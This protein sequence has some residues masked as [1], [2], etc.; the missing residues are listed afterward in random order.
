MIF[1]RKNHDFYH[2][3]LDGIKFVFMNKKSCK[4]NFQ[5]LNQITE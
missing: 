3:F 1:V 4:D 5:Y 2:V